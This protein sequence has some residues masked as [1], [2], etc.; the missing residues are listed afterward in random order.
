MQTKKQLID[1]ALEA[2]K[3]AGINAS[4]A[5][6]SLSKARELMQEEE[7]EAVKAY[8]EGMKYKHRA[9]PDARYVL[10]YIAY[11]PKTPWCLVRVDTGTSFTTRL[12][13]RPE[14]AFGASEHLFDR[15]E[16]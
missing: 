3:T 6:W 9:Y 14:Q 13:T 1:K 8:R 16:D 10:T 12:H 15:V 2:I 11:H 4:N 5:A 7:K